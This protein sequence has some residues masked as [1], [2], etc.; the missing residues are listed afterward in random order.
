MVTIFICEV[1]RN[2]IYYFIAAAFKIIKGWLPAAAV[3]KIKFLTKSNM[4]EYLTEENRLEEW[5][6]G[7]P[8]QYQWEHEGVE[9]GA[10]EVAFEGK[11]CIYW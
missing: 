11:T 2:L 10:K 1:V 8:W 4:G 6:G 5:G 9:N 3:K 7:D